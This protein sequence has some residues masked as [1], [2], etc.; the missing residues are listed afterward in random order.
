M[1]YEEEE[2]EGGGGRSDGNQRSRTKVEKR[3]GGTVASDL[4]KGT[5]TRVHTEK[6]QR[7]T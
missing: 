1:Q 4:Q 7:S 5:K 2:L 3:E 6:T